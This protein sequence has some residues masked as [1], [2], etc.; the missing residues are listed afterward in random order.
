MLLLLV[1]ALVLL[2]SVDCLS[3]SFSYCGCED[4]SC[5]LSSEGHGQ[6]SQPTADP[7]FDQA[8]QRWSRRLNFHPGLDGCSRNAGLRLSQSALPGLTDWSTAP[9][10]GLLVVTQSWQFHWRTASEPRAPASVF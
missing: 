3:D 8:I 9:R 6:N 1:P 7:S 4:L 2:A 10:P 5:A